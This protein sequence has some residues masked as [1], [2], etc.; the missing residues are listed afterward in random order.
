M[1]DIQLIQC[2]NQHYIKSCH[3]QSCSAI[4]CLSSGINILAGGSSVRLISERKR[5]NPDWYFRKFFF[6]KQF[7][8]KITLLCVPMLHV[9]SS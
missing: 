9:F 6:E 2:K 1:V 3:R 8:Y 5:I 7:S 4:S